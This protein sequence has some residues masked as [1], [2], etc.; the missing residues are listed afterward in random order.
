MLWGVKHAGLATLHPSKASRPRTKAV[1]RFESGARLRPGCRSRLWPFDQARDIDTGVSSGGDDTAM[2]QNIGNLL[3]R[4]SGIDEAAPY[5][6]SQDLDPRS[7]PAASSVG[8]VHC[9]L[10]DAS[11]YRL[12]TRRNVPN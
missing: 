10:D 6:V 2:A 4:R 9:L 5:G 3:H 1:P 8:G 11:A 7:A 12:A